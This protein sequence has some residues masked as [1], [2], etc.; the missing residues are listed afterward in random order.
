MERGEDQ[1]VRIAQPANLIA[2]FTVYYYSLKHMPVLETNML[3]AFLLA[4]T[5]AC[6][7]LI[8]E[9]YDY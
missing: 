1:V 6:D 9:F 7:A 8:F 5:G 4:R 2:S 3:A